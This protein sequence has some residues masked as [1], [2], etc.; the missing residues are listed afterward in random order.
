M[1]HIFI[2]TNFFIQCQVPQNISWL[3][4]FNA[5][6]LIQL[7]ILRTV[8]VEIDR[9]KQDGNQ[10]RS[11]RARKA[12]E[13]IRKIILAEGEK[14]TIKQNSPFIEMTVPPATK[15]S[16]RLPDFI[17]STRADDQIIAEIIGF[18][19]SCQGG[20]V[21]LLTHDTNP[22]LT[23]K[24]CGIECLII[25]DNWL[26][27][28]EPN[29]KDKKIAELEKY[30]IELRKVTP[31][32]KIE[33]EYQSVKDTKEIQ[34]IVTI[35][36]K[37][38]EN[39]LEDI[40]G[41]IKIKHPSKIDFNEKDNI[42]PSTPEMNYFISAISNYPQK[43]YIPPSEQEIEK[44]LK[45]DCPKWTLSLKKYIKN[46]PVF[47]EDKSRKIPVA[48]SLENYGNVPAD[49]ALIEFKAHGGILFLRKDEDDEKTEQEVITS[50]PMPP[51]PPIGKREMIHNS[52]LD[53][54]GSLA[55]LNRLSAFPFEDRFLSKNV[56]LFREKEKDRNSFY[57]KTGKYGP[58]ADSIIFQCEEF[59]HKIDPE[60]F[61]LHIVVPPSVISGSDQCVSAT[62]SSKN[63]HE[64]VKHLIKI[65]IS[66][67]QE[68]SSQ[69]VLDFLQSAN[70][71]N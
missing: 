52:F 26:L 63:L 7:L 12:N 30:I 37:L 65:H 56:D 48:F 64:P 19:E 16:T 1:K 53:S 20:E 62:F 55:S 35:Y 42:Q 9:L 68:N 34:K 57:Y 18:K 36:Q 3:D 66:V 58:P 59:R 41:R 10:R 60:I 13:L 17:D 11:K 8:Q 6:D 5:S 32:I 23:A 2:D 33:A 69:K 44:Y 31:E 38:K 43:K 40:I 21:Y 14:I 71:I 45:E 61:H 29:S 49:N 24:R 39:E 15:A 47:Y 51:T 25:P 27:P 70:H 28:P 67:K 50:F 4:L 22:L 54:L 46:I